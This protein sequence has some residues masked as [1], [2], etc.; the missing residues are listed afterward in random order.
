M[1]C[2][3]GKM[4]MAKMTYIMRRREYHGYIDCVI[5]IMVLALFFCFTTMGVLCNQQILC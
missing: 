1:T 4:E 3:L 2:I 5:F